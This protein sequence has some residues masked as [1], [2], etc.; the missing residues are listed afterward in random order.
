MIFGSEWGNSKVTETSEWAGGAYWPT[1]FT[2]R[3]SREEVDYFLGWHTNDNTGRE[4]FFLWEG[5]V[6]LIVSTGNT[7]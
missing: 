5:P 3:W 2:F 6:S 4:F 7:H 1:H